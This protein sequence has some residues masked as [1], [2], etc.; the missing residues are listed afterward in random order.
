MRIA[1]WKALIIEL[2]NIRDIFENS[3]NEREFRKKIKIMRETTRWLWEGDVLPKEYEMLLMSLLNDK[4]FFMKDNVI[5]M[6][7]SIFR[8]LEIKMKAEEIMRK[9]EEETRKLWEKMQ[10]S[11]M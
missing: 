7:S 11:S 8:V 9:H 3:K 2:I 1:L 5:E 4:C 6:L 10:C